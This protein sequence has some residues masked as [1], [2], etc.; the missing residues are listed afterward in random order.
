MAVVQGNTV[1]ASDYN[2]LRGEVNRWF[3]DNYAGGISFGDGNQT[4]GWGGSLTPVV[5]QGD[6]VLASE[7]NVLIDRAYI[8]TNICNNVSGSITRVASGGVVTA[9]K[10]N[11]T[12]TKSDDITTNRL[13]IEAGQLSLAAGGSSIRTINWSAGIDATFR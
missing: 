2:T 4:Y 1:L 10:Y 6:P 7:M 8:G 9:A 12:E 13:D 5:V 11:E 3:S